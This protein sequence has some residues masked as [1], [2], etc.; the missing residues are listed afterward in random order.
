MI[1]LGKAK[2]NRDGECRENTKNCERQWVEGEPVAFKN[3]KKVPICLTCANW[4][5]LNN[6]AVWA[7]KQETRTE[8]RE[9]YTQNHADGAIETLL[10]SI[11]QSLGTIASEMTAIREHI[12]PAKPEATPAP[13]NDV[14]D[15]RPPELMDESIRTSHNGKYQYRQLQTG[16][17]EFVDGPDIKSAQGTYEQLRKENFPASAALSAVTTSRY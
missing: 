8:A 11:A 9:S 10:Q 5:V 7:K 3:D 6:R 1:E 4:L 16:E 13:S 12:V 14:I 15:M 2:A 17:Y